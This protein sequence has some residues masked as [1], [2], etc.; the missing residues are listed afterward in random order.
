METRLL[1]LRRELPRV[2]PLFAGE[3]KCAPAHC[4]GPAVR[5]YYLVH[6][7][8]SG[9]GVLLAD[10]RE[11]PVEEGEMFWIRPEEV[12]T[13]RADR[14]DPWH[15]AW[16]GFEG[17]AG[18]DALALRRVIPC[19]EGRR[20]FREIAD[21]RKAEV[22]REAVITG[23]LVELFGRLS[24]APAGAGSRPVQAAQSYMDHNYGEPLSIARLA[25]YLGLERTYFSALFKRETGLSPKEYLTRRRMERACELLAEQKLTPSEAA[26]R[27]GYGD[28]FQFSKAFKKFTGLPPSRW[29]KEK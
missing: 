11:W 28:L 18:W 14:K 19:P 6:Y 9:R 12:T 23:L 22:D 1:L 29:R 8:F 2:R 21:V 7:V 16:V 13:Y 20:I 27:C 17:G 10:G 25:G 15:Y 4:Y 24:P 3:E 5:G 26:V